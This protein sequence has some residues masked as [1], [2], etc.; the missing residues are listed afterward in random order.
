MNSRRN[1]WS[2]LAVT[3]GLLLFGAVPLTAQEGVVAGTVTDAGSGEPI[4]GAQ[5]SV[6]GSQRGTLSASDGSYQIEGVS[7]GE[8]EIRVQR[9]GYTT[10][11]QEVVVAAGA[12]ATANFA[13][14]TAVVDI[15]EVVVTGVAGETS[16]AKVPFEIATLDAEDIQVAPTTAG[17][18]IQGKVAGAAVVQGSGRPGDPPS[19]LLRG[20]TSIDASGRSQ[21]PLYIVDGVILG[22]SLVDIDALDIERIEVVKGAAASSLYGSRAA[23]GVIQISTRR[24]AGIADDEVRYTVRTSFGQSDLPGTFLLSKSH[25]YLLTADGSQFVTLGGEPCN[26]IEC[27]SV[28]IAGQRAEP[29]EDPDEWNTFQINQWPGRTFDQ[30]ER[31]FSGGSFAEQYVSASGRSGA[32]NFHVSFSR[33]DD[34]GV[35]LGQEGFERNNFRVNLDQSLQE[36]LQ[37]SASAFYSRSVATDDAAGTFFDL[38]RQPAGVDLFA[39][40]DDP[41]Q[42]CRDDPENIILLPD[43]T[44]RESE[45]P[46]YALL[47]REDVQDRGRFLGSANLV[48]SAFDWLDLDANVSYDRLDFETETIFPKGFRIVNAPFRT[49]GSLSR[50]NQLTEALNASATATLR[51]DLNQYVANRTQLRYLYEQ[52]DATFNQALG[53]DFTVADVPQ[54]DNLDPDQLQAFSGSFPVRADGYYLITNFDILDRYIIDALVRNDGSSLFGEDERRQWYYRAAGAWRMSQ[55]PWFTVPA[56]DELKFRYSYGTAGSRPSFAAQFETFTVSAGRIIPVNL[57]NSLLKPEFSTEQEAGIDAV[58]LNGR[59]AA[60]LTYANKVTED[61]ILQVPLPAFTGFQSQ[62]QNAGTLESTVWEASLD[63]RLVQTD[64]F[65]WSARLLY[66]HSEATITELNVPAFNYGVGGQGLGSVFFAREGEEYGTLYGVQFATSCA[67]LPEGT[68]CDGFTVNDDGWLVWVGDSSLS[69]NLWGTSSGD[70][71]TFVRGSAVN[72]GTPFGGECVDRISGERTQ[73]CPVGNAIPDYSLSF[74]NTLTWRGLS[75]Y[76]LLD[77]EQGFDVYNQPLQWATFKRKTALCDQRGVPTEQQKPLGYCDA[78]YGVSGLRPSSAFVEDASYV[79][80]RELALRYTFGEEQLGRVAALSAFSGLTFSLTGRN[81]VTWTDFRGYD[82]E[83]G[84]AGGNTGSAAVA[85]VAGFQYPNFRTW[86]L[87]L[88]LNF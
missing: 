24:G 31:F 26:F 84:I 64:D 57:G 75:L 68:S 17:A 47:E 13:L 54:L 77:A 63:G 87:G 36:N 44:N 10:V 79:K 69:D 85:R 82:P 78:L 8:Q 62:F 32:T 6:V 43:P 73:L 40:E 72:W 22:S 60:G 81:L 61:Q 39:C 30:V 48:Y 11:T 14:G 55:E 27:E 88:E 46:I 18:A 19:I 49:E 86:T 70:A 76:G 80:L 33:L 74:A 50:F 25:E 71:G 52:Q 65:S 83:V 29:G 38:T 16:K 58:F 34:E 56:V 7:A 23:N 12:T 53:S 35:L 1:I 37:L 15:A 59:L 20:A 4:S 28:Q 3:A 2:C 66:D 45:N 5:I 21:E 42:S 67:S 9:I 41:S 51:F